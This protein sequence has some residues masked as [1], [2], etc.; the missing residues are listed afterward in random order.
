MVC[1]SRML[2]MRSDMEIVF[3]QSSSIYLGG[4]SDG[5]AAR[6]FSESVSHVSMWGTKR[7][8]VQ[9]LTVLFRIC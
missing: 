3:L 7:S 9:T 2:G 5:D 6:A 1:V 8:A 4:R